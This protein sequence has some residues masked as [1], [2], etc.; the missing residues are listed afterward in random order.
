MYLSNWMLALLIKYNF[1][2]ICQGVSGRV[3]PNSPLLFEVDVLRV[4]STYYVT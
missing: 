4:C 1:V 3:P 2:K